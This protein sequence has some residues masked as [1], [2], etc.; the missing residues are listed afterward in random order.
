LIVNSNLPYLHL[1][2]S[3]LVLLHVN[4]STCTGSCFR[5]FCEYRYSYVVLYLIPIYL[6][7]YFSLHVEYLWHLWYILYV[8]TNSTRSLSLII[9]GGKSGFSVVNNVVVCMS[10]SMYKMS[11]KRTDLDQIFSVDMTC[12]KDQGIDLVPPSPTVTALN[13]WSDQI[14][15]GDPVLGGEGF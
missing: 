4:S 3:V 10:Q 15:H 11:E 6:Y 7:L 13:L 1:E 9:V 12:Y 8:S 14:W 2:V 5:R